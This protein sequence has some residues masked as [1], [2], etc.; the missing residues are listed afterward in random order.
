MMIKMK[1]RRPD[2]ERVVKY[3]NYGRMYGSLGARL[4]AGQRTLTPYVGVRILRP[5]PK[6]SSL[7]GSEMRLFT[8]RD[9]MVTPVTWAF[10]PEWLTFEE[11]WVLSGMEPETMQEV[12]DDDG[13]DLSD[14]GLI[15]RDSLRE[16]QEVLLLVN[17]LRDRWEKNSD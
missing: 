14:D 17:Q 15:G 4:M 16:F 2:K 3:R 9:G 1:E 6:D 10:A 7:G 8:T 13:V 11:A 5:Q 12:I